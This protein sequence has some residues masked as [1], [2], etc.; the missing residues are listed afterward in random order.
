MGRNFKYFCRHPWLVVIHGIMKR[1]TLRV[2]FEGFV[3]AVRRTLNTHD[4]YVH[5]DNARIIL[6]AGQGDK[7]LV[8]ISSSHLPVDEVKQQLHAEGLHVFDGLW[9][10]ADD[11]EL[12]E[13]P[14]LGAVSYRANRDK[15]GVWVEAYPSV[16]TE[17]RVLQDLYE[18]FKSSGEIGE[19]SFDEFETAAQASVVVLSPE[20]IENFFTTKRLQGV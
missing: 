17:A 20:Q 7:N 1:M 19:I 6:S 15:T 13:M 14:Y 3:D 11:L 8:V 18:E 9:S 4:A 5:T 16:P 10:I 2:P 12:L